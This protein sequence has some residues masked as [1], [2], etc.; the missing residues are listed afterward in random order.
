M[1]VQWVA[2]ECQGQC[3]CF[4]FSLSFLLVVLRSCGSCFSFRHHI[5][6]QDGK[7]VGRGKGKGTT[8]AASVSSKWESRCFLETAPLADFVYLCSLYLGHITILSCKRGRKK[9]QDCQDQL[10]SMTAHGL[11]LALYFSKW[12]L[13]LLSRKRGIDIAETMSSI[14]HCPFSLQSELVVWGN[15]FLLCFYTFKSLELCL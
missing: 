13:V 2:W 6:V 8:P 5:F 15:W 1:L 4:F 12:N 7:K 9:E 14:F 11:E 3:T 10:R